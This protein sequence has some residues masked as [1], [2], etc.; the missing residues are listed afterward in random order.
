VEILSTADGVEVG[1][2]CAKE[3]RHAPQS[4]LRCRIPL[5]LLPA[6]SPTALELSSNNLFELMTDSSLELAEPDQE[7]DSPEKS[8]KFA[9]CELDDA[10]VR[11]DSEQYEVE[12]EEWEPG[13]TN[14]RATAS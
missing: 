4:F 11:E 10:E 12:L 2:R 6:A 14:W 3:I 13:E 7:E 8:G 9:I 5:T 1:S